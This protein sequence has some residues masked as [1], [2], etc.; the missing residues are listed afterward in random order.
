[1]VTLVNL[2]KYSYN[3]KN[4]G[5]NLVRVYGLVTL[6]STNRHLATKKSKS[7]RQY[8]TGNEACTSGR[9]TSDTSGSDKNIDLV[10]VKAMCRVHESTRWSI[11]ILTLMWTWFRPPFW[12]LLMLQL[13]RP[14][15][16]NLP[17]L[18]STFH[19][20]YPF[21]TFSILPLTRIWLR[22]EF[23]NFHDKYSNDLDHIDARLINE[24]YMK[25]ANICVH[26]IENYLEM[27]K[28]CVLFFAGYIC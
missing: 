16:S 8:Y 12:D 2:V 1:M 4:S 22:N 13:L 23:R 11:T 14:N 20:E 24:A 10:I 28:W 7:W 6:S 17:C 15:S 5:V 9:M 25:F 18:Y 19:L 21:G 26:L 3:L 27:S